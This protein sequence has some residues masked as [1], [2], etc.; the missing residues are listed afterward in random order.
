MFIV[1]QKSIIELECL[2]RYVFSF[3]FTALFF[4]LIFNIPKWKKYQYNLSKYKTIS[5]LIKKKVKY[6]TFVW[7]VT[8]N[9]ENLISVSIK[10]TT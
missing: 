8:T 2:K 10:I 5:W 1:G 9:L 6:Q 3:A 4:F 7:S